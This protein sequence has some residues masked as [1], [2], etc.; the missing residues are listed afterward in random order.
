MSSTSPEV[1][2]KVRNQIAKS[3]WAHGY[4]TRIKEDEKLLGYS[5]TTD[6]NSVKDEDD[7]YWQR[8][9]LRQSEKLYNTNSVRAILTEESE[10]KYL[11][12]TDEVKSRYFDFK[13]HILPTEFFN[14]QVLDLDLENEQQL[15]DFLVEWGFPYSP[16]RTFYTYNQISELIVETYRLRE[17]AEELASYYE[18]GGI[19][20]DDVDSPSLHMDPWT[21]SFQYQLLKRREPE[22]ARTFLSFVN[23]E[24]FHEEA[25]KQT[26]K[27]SESLHINNYYDA[28]GLEGQI[29]ISAQE[30]KSTLAFYKDFINREYNK[31]TQCLKGEQ[32]EFVNTLKEDF[33]HEV[34]NRSR[35]HL[36]F[37]TCISSLDNTLTAAIS[38]QIIQTFADTEKPWK[39]CA[40][41]TCDKW[42]KE[43]QSDFKRSKKDS[44]YCS[45]K[46]SDK[47]G[48]INKSRAAK[49]RIQH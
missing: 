11:E 28:W 5:M 14:H 29:V 40:C 47:Q 37:H 19:T 20:A 46:C 24:F 31:A 15:F 9:K 48:N 6:K 30:A 27:L 32:V 38:E 39:K 18:E 7:R 23:P 35:Q 33:I 1:L 25:I 13:L 17:M 43:K 10:R 2:L 36:G 26:S 3:S 4:V 8:K 16:F 21:E 22:D 41:E 45:K 44:I 34:I 49:N 42:F 12:A